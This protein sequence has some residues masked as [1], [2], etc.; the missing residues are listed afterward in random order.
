MMITVIIFLVILNFT[1]TIFDI[2]LS[3][4]YYIRF[5]SYNISC[6]EVFIARDNM[7]EYR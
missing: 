1:L 3:Y 7:F 2:L 5:N 4:S 6:Y